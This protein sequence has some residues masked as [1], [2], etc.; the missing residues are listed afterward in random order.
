MF[1][2]NLNNMEFMACHGVLDYEKDEPQK[3]IIDL[4]IETDK[5]VSAALTDDINEALNYVSVFELVRKIM[6]DEQYDMIETIAK[7]ISERVLTLDSSCISVD[8]KV[9]KANP[10][11]H[12]FTGCVSCEYS[13]FG[14]E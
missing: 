8:V 1:Y 14:S 6:I 10:P 12:G 3:F 2:L 13:A 11:I 7:Q 4:K 5:V 9:T